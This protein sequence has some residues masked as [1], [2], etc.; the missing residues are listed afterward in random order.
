[1]VH[2]LAHGDWA[3]FLVVGQHYYLRL[4]TAV[5][6]LKFASLLVSSKA[7]QKVGHL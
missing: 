7:Y 4:M 3:V 2:W 1:L 5:L 6:R